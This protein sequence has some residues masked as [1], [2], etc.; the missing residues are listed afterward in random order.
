MPKCCI[1]PA[2]AIDSAETHISAIES[3]Q[4]YI[5]GVVTCEPI[6]SLLIQPPVPI[7][8]ISATVTSDG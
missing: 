1:S 3:E 8:P 4:Q 2:E 6:R 7:E 5:F